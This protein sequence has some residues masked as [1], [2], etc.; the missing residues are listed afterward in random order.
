MNSL[1]TLSF[2]IDHDNSLLRI[3]VVKLNKLVILI[4]LLIS[5]AL[6]FLPLFIQTFHLSHNIW[7]LL[8][9][10]MGRQAAKYW[11]ESIEVE[12]KEKFCFIYVTEYKCIENTIELHFCIFEK[13]MFAMRCE[14][15]M[16]GFFIIV[17]FAR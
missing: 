12:L 14:I 16:H 13:S 10:R 9:C 11:Y 6:L 8:F 5:T 4:H 15:M 1:C 2:C 7:I 3:Y 17:S